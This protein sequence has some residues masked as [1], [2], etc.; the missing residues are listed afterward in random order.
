VRPTRVVI[1]GMGV[2]AANGSGLEAFW[3]SIL[4]CESGIGPIT[5]FDAAD[6]PI[7]VAGEVKHFDIRHYFNGAVKPKRLGRHTQ[8]CL[9][10]TKM[11]MDDADCTSESMNG[12]SPIPI[13]IGV[14]SSAMDVVEK[15]KDT[16]QTKGIERISSYTVSSSQPHAVASE[17]ANQFG[18]EAQTQTISSACHAGLDAIG[19]GAE[20]V[21]K[22]RADIVIAG[23]TDS[24]TSSLGVALMGAS[25]LS[26]LTGE[27][28]PRMLS[29][30]FDRDRQGGI[31]A[32]GAGVLILENFENA[33]ARGA[34]IYAEISGYGTCNDAPGEEHGSGLETSLAEALANSRR[35]PV[36][37][38]YVCAHGPSDPVVDRVETHA[39]KKVLGREA[40]R[41]PV[42]SVKGVTG[43]PLSAAGPMEVMAAALSI[44]D[45]IVPPT[46]NYSNR[47]PECDLD[48]VPLKARKVPVDVAA[49][50]V[51]GLG[52]GNS[53]LVLEKAPSL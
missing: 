18:I 19:I 15:G 11:A 49:V 25:G 51:H 48:Y 53:S 27:I 24:P 40:Y 5:S 37:V 9:A 32:E 17:I 22:G 1:T 7:R 41:V 3:K 8:L 10:A 46:A 42:S 23:G 20:M 47:D 39:I 44:R 16:W 13:V 26:P 45:G 30:P 28:D 38:D 43:N 2:L 21:R 52:G 35:R 34:S 33:M 31:I 14:S 4:F 36:D 12:F 29:R 50:N 6:Y